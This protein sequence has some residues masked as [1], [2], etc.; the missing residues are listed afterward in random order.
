MIARSSLQTPIP[1]ER[2]PPI[3]KEIA[4]NKKMYAALWWFGTGMVVVAALMASDKHDEVHDGAYHAGEF[5]GM[6]FWVVVLFFLGLR[7]WKIGRRAS[8]AIEL[9]NAGQTSFVLAERLLVAVD[10]RGVS[11]PEA[12]FKISSK[13]ATMLTALPAATLVAKDSNLPRG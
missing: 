5:A 3:A 2:I 7:L 9:A 11:L 6:M 13:H 4:D 10:A 8:R 1:A 12:T